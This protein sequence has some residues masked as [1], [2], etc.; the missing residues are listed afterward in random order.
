MHTS[1]TIFLQLLGL[2]IITS[3]LVVGLR[4]EPCFKPLR[5]YGWTFCPT[6]TRNVPTRV[7]FGQKMS[8]VRP[9]FQALYVHSHVH[10][11]LI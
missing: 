6:K 3:V 11:A 8:N 2:K 9:L 5:I 4:N 1:L 10:A 7:N